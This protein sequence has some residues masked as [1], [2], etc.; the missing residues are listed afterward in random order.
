MSIIYS[1][2]IGGAAG[3]SIIP[4]RCADGSLKMATNIMSSSLLKFAEKKQQCLHL[5][6]LQSIT[7][8]TP[9]ISLL[10]QSSLVF[11]FA[12]RMEYDRS[13]NPKTQ[14]RAVYRWP[15]TGR[16]ESLSILLHS[17]RKTPHCASDSELHQVMLCLSKMS[18]G[19]ISCVHMVGHRRVHFMD[20]QNIIFLCMKSWGKNNL[21][22]M[23]W[24]YQLCPQ[25]D[26]M[27][28]FIH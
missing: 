7:C 18:M 3:S 15:T 19:R 2:W 8:F 5:G 11:K 23:T 16:H 17:A 10:K 27:S 21:F 4:F 20:F 25:K 26:G 28:L 12:M 6:N 14:K 22:Q 9:H 13:Q 1:K 24:F